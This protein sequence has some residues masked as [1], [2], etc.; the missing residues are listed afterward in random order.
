MAGGEDEDGTGRR[1]KVNHAGAPLW[2]GDD[3]KKEAGWRARDV[4]GTR[5]RDDDAWV[6][7]GQQERSPMA[8]AEAGGRVS[9]DR[10]GG[11]LD[12]C[13]QALDRGREQRVA[14]VEPSWEGRRACKPA[15]PRD[16]D[17]SRRVS[18]RQDTRRDATTRPR[19]GALPATRPET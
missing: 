19:A 14:L 1:P 15:R 12:V 10:S 8:R 9:A 18:G 3:R 4:Q 7:A 2:R 11:R 13:D 16:A 6:S 5:R 17:G